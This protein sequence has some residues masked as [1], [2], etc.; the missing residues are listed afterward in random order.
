VVREHFEANP[1]RGEFT[2]VIAGQPSEEAVWSQERL[3]AA[4]RAAQPLAAPARQAAR[5]L[6][7]RS[8]WKKR[9][10]Y[11]LILKLNRGDLDG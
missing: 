9:A 4:I 6:A 8:G 3:V 11:D 5:E 1:P 7:D 10:V 2:L